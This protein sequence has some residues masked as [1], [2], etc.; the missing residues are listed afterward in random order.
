MHRCPTCRSLVRPRQENP[1]FPFC[2]S[3]CRAVDLGRWFTG[4][5]HVPGDPAPDASPENVNDG[6]RP[7]AGAYDH[8]SERDA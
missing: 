2:T 4:G 7:E 3:R 8:E 5:Y 1:A 6:R